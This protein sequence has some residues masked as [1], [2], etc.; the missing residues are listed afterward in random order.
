[1]KTFRIENGR[2]EI[3]L[4]GEDSRKI[5]PGEYMWDLRIV[6]NPVYAKN[7]GAMSGDDSTVLSVFAGGA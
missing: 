2:V 4:K 1:M 3:V 6:T 5:E 7:G